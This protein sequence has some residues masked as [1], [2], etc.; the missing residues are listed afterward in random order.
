MQQN[1]LART[2]YVRKATTLLRLFVH[3][4]FTLSYTEA[5]FI[6]HKHTHTHTHTHFQLGIEI[7]RQ[8]KH[9]TN[10]SNIRG[11][12]MYVE[13]PEGLLTSGTV[14][15]HNQGTTNLCHFFD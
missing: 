12:Y 11:R 13:P 10:C 7:H 3:L 2:V 8:Y 5:I 1:L 9:V 14:T 15:R 4:S 6:S